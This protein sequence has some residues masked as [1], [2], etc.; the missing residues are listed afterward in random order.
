MIVYLHLQLFHL[1]LEL[2]LGGG[3]DGADLVLEFVVGYLYQSLVVLYK[4]LP[5]KYSTRP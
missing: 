4:F 1:L 2:L 3:L 5:T